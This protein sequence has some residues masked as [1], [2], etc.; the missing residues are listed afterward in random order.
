M[1]K[2]MTY[3]ESNMKSERK[4]E[5]VGR[6]VSFAQAEEDDIFYWADKT[7][8]ER[9]AETERLRRLIWT[10]R[11]GSYPTKIEKVGRVISKSEL[12]KNDW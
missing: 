10:H 1:L 3:W 9:I 12:D 2:T 7:P 8:Q 4:I 6:V 11:L 5:V